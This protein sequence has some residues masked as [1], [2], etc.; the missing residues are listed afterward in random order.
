MASL[1][2]LQ[3][4][5]GHMFADEALLQRALRHAS[6]NVDDDNEALEFIGDRVLGLAIS[7]ILMAR[8]ATEPEG[9]LSRRLSQLVSGKSCAKIAKLWDLGAHLKTDS[10]IRNRR[11]IPNAV[12]ADGCEAVL[13]AVFLDAGF[14][15]AQKLVATHWADLLG[16]QGDVPIDSK[17]ALQELTA[18]HGHDFPTYEIIEQSGA[19]H[20]PHFS[21]EVKSGLGKAQGEGHSRKAAE[22]DAAQTLL[23]QLQDGQAK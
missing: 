17:T 20:A 13:G 6:L 14:D 3:K 7:Q 16:A 23:T 19:A 1:D 15:V 2:A 10:G 9:A 22:Q 5:L 18:K 12:L 21:V 8:Y 11:K 4:T